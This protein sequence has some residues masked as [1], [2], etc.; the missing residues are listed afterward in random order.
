MSYSSLNTIRICAAIDEEIEIQHAKRI[1]ERNKM[2]DDYISTQLQELFWD[3][4]SIHLENEYIEL[5]EAHVLAFKNTQRHFPGLIADITA[6][7]GISDEEMNDVLI[8]AF[9]M[10]EIHGEIDSEKTNDELLDKSVEDYKNIRAKF[11]D[12]LKSPAMFP[13]YQQPLCK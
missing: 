4:N 7:L 13:P 8:E 12:F 9:K 1:S 11:D 6:E 3:R 2:N 5:H 10:A